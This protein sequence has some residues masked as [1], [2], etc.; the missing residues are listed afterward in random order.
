[1]SEIIYGKRTIIEALKGGIDL[2]KLYIFSN[3]NAKEKYLE[4]LYN[5]S[6]KKRIIPVDVSR[7]EL[8]LVSGT[9]KHGGVAAEI[10]ERDFVSVE[11]ILSYAKSKNEQP[12]LL[13][14]NGRIT[15]NYPDSSLLQ[16]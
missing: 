5:L 4:E 10:S 7:K 2:K 15:S 12:F 16:L 6:G 3:M 9:I 14:L 8:A 1:M 13:I 11:D